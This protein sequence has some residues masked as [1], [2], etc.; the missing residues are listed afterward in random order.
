[1]ASDE[2]GLKI[3]KVAK[4]TGITQDRLRVWERRYGA[5]EP[6]RSATDR[7]LYSFEDVE[8]LKLM[9]L[10]TDGGD[11]I[12]RVANLDIQ[13]LRDRLASSQQAEPT[14]K[15]HNTSPPFSNAILVGDTLKATFKQE[16][17]RICGLKVSDHYADSEAV[18]AAEKVQTADILIIQQ[19]TLGPD[20]INWIEKIRKKTQA[21]HSFL[22]YRFATS[23]LINE[24]STAEITLIRAPL[25]TRNLN[26]YIQ[27][28]RSAAHQE[29]PETN[30]FITDA[31]QLHDA[32]V[33]KYDDVTLAKI[34]AISPTIDCE[35][36]NHLADLLA[37]LTAFETYS[38]ECKSI[39]E[40]EA[41]LHAYLNKAAAN[42]RHI[43]E[44]ALT[45][46]LEYEGIDVD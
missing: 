42:A 1:M 44:N 23:G 26:R 43:I 35:C 21:R 13:A 9:K 45:V 41:E 2:S 4:L 31:N 11:S 29:M 36:P 40:K 28:L 34:A 30:K 33:R 19:N 14:F 12:S 38:N 17:S 32:P 37:D 22:I 15:T 8:R 20:S 25:N 7:R 16:L 6:A 5:I 46:V 3:G 10:L 18:A 39:N 27:A 24:L